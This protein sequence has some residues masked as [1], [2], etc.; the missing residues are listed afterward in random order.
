[1]QARFLA[2][3][4]NFVWVLLEGQCVGSGRWLVTK[5]LELTEVF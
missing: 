5:G 1:M 4:G 2:M 3:L